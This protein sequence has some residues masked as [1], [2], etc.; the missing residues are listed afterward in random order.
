MLHQTPGI[1]KEDFQGDEN[2]RE[3]IEAS[4]PTLVFCGHFHWEQPLLELVNKT[5]VLN[6]DSRVVVLLNHLKL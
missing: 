5:Q 6:V 2:I 3:I 4:T 1:L